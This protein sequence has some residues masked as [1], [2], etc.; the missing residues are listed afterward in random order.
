MIRT[1][2]L[3]VAL[4][5]LGAVVSSAQDFPKPGPEH[6]RLQEMEGTWDA[7]MDMGGHKSKCVATY[8]SICGGMWIENDFEGDLGGIP[9][10][11]HGL[12][13]YDL[14][15]KEY[16]GVWVDSMSSTPMQSVGTYDADKKTLKMTGT[17]PGPDGKPTKHTMTSHMKDA[18]HMTFNM[19]MVG[20]DGKEQQAF[21]I[22]YTRRKK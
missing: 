6:A 17:A 2:C 19:S 21:T 11:G 12:D 8:E 10:K 22:E 13:G 15:K 18:D 9:F 7:V 20:S 16:V 4:F 3:T 5:C 14:Q 1:L